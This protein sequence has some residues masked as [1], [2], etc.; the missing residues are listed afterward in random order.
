[1]PDLRLGIDLGGTK[2]E[3]IVL[4]QGIEAFRKRI[5]TPAHSYPEIIKAIAALIVECRQQFGSGLSVGIGMPGA[6]TA[7]GLVKNSN[8]VC[9]N[10]KPFQQDLEMALQQSVRIMNDANCFTLSESVDGAAANGNAVFGVIL[11]TGVGGG[12]VIQKSPL[13]G[14]NSIAGEWG[15]NPLPSTA[16]R[17]STENR[18]CYC[19][20]VNCVETFLCGKG[21][22]QTYFEMTG[23]QATSTAIGQLAQQQ[24]AEAIKACCIYTQQLAASLATVIN[25]L[26]PDVIVLGGGVSNLPMLAENTQALLPQY[27]FSNVV[28]TRVVRNQHGDSSG[29]R[30]AAWLWPAV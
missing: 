28:N 22:A 19:G 14:C 2:I 18:L 5:P 27:V 4:E 9:M 3:V 15:H 7:D 11:G 8:T 12:I 23:V 16:P 25:V 21:L 20:K 29:V 30:G 26:D 13:L 17:I 6:L 1:M 10:G 24:D